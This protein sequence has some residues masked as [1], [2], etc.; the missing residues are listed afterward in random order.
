MLLLGL[1]LVFQLLLLFLQMD[2]IDRRRRGRDVCEADV[3]LLKL[4]LLLLP[5][6]RVCRLLRRRLRRCC[7]LGDDR[8]DTRDVDTA[9]R[10]P[11]APTRAFQ[12]NSFHTLTDGRKA[13]QK[14]RM[15]AHI[16]L[17]TFR[18]PGKAPEIKVA[19][20]RFKG[21]RPK[22]GGHNFRHEPFFI[23]DFEGFSIR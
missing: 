10:R 20:K 5:V 7:R 18:D 4:L 1:R 22:K 9:Q 2:M 15:T 6:L 13:F 21:L 11:I 3:L 14:Q 19:L 16:F 23:M 8:L 12:H 17:G